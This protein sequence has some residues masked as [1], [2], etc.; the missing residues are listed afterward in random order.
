M[1][2]FH[3]FVSISL[4]VV[5]GL[6]ASIAASEAMRVVRLLTTKLFAQRERAILGTTKA[7]I[8]A[9]HEASEPLDRAL[10]K[11]TLLFVA[12][13]CAPDTS[14]NVPMVFKTIEFFAMSL[15][16]IFGLLMAVSHATRMAFVTADAFMTT[17][18]L[19]STP[20]ALHHVNFFTICLLALFLN[21]VVHLDAFIHALQEGARI[22]P[23]FVR[24]LKALPTTSSTLGRIHILTIHHLATLL[25]LRV[26]CDLVRKVAHAVCMAI[27]EILV[28]S[29]PFETFTRVLIVALA[30]AVPALLKLVRIIFLARLF[31]FIVPALMLIVHALVVASH[32]ALIV[33]ATVTTIARELL[34]APATTLH[35]L[36]LLPGIKLRACLHTFAAMFLAQ[37]ASHAFAMAHHETL[38][39]N[40]LLS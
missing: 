16:L 27:Q 20:Q 1:A 12:L 28:S 6:T 13:A 21:E 5:H 34:M 22:L 2:R 18:A 24:L 40:A 23:A 30:A 10:S 37:G 26:L 8:L 39:L 4:A 33:H 36:T 32:E 29:T 25:H 14:L 15:C 38:L 11:L 9:S 31:T 35:A 3:A 19:E 17:L 7:V